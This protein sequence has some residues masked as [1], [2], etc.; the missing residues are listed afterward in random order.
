MT[1]SPYVAESDDAYTDVNQAAD[2]YS[3]AALLVRLITGRLTPPEHLSEAIDTLPAE[4]PDSLRTE[5][6]DAVVRSGSATPTARSLAVHLAFDTAWIRARERQQ[7]EQDVVEG[8]VLDR[9]SAPLTG[10]DTLARWA[11]AYPSAGVRGGAAG[12]D[13]AAGGVRD[14]I[15]GIRDRLKGR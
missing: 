1:P 3:L 15:K 8:E 14:A 6:R 10:E 5:L 2:V 13:G 11:R 12:G 9:E 4:L 7:R